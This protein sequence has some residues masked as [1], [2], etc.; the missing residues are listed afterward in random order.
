MSCTSGAG[1]PRLGTYVALRVAHDTAAHH[2]QPGRCLLPEV[3][4]DRCQ[5]LTGNPFGT[6]VCHL[7]PLRPGD[8]SVTNDLQNQTGQDHHGPDLNFLVELRA[9]S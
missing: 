7:G 2:R 6:G 3:G 5:A 9:S 4:W 1:G 8:V